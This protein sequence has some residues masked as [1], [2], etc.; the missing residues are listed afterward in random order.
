MMRRQFGQT[1]LA[2][3]PQKSIQFNRNNFNSFWLQVCFHQLPDNHSTGTYLRFHLSISYNFLPHND[4][5][6]LLTILKHSFRPQQLRNTIIRKYSKFIDI[7][8][9]SYPFSTKFVINMADQQLRMFVKVNLVS[10]VYT[11]VLKIGKIISQYV[12]KR[13]FWFLGGFDQFH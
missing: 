13:N 7:R 1:A 9:L 5:S 6:Q 11:M 4:F 8:K 2:Q 12:E 10:F 3:L